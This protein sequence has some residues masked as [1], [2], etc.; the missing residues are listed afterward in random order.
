MQLCNVNRYLPNH[1][2]FQKVV[3]YN[4]A[5]VHL[6]EKI[7]FYMSKTSEIPPKTY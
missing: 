5:D 2:K 6:R 4:N 1:L 7:S 3:N